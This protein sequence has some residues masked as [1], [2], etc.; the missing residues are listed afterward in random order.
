MERSE[1]PAIKIERTV[2]QSHSR[3]RCISGCER[4]VAILRAGSRD[5]ALTPLAGSNAKT[6]SGRLGQ[7]HSDC[8]D[9]LDSKG[10]IVLLWLPGTLARGLA[11]QFYSAFSRSDARQRCNSD[12]RVESATICS[13]GE[14]A[15][16]AFLCVRC[17]FG[18]GDSAAE[19]D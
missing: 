10:S 19:G 17:F 3:R 4:L 18:E 15:G 14:A 11:A 5:Q 16:S 2:P 9:R 6:L 12:L 13:A 7:L 1:H 8:A